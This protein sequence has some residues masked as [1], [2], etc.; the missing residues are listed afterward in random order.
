M[1]QTATEKSVSYTFTLRACALHFL[2]SRNLLAGRRWL[3]LH[4]FGKP[5]GHI[6]FLRANFISRASSGAMHMLRCVTMHVQIIEWFDRAA[7]LPYQLTYPTQGF[8][9]TLNFGDWPIKYKVPCSGILASD[10]DAQLTRKLLT[11]HPCCWTG[12]ALPCWQAWR[13]HVVSRCVCQ[14]LLR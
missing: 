11:S 6:P 10:C 2:S 13:H 4:S 14:C 1:Q 9:P 12:C 5:C 3:L 8:G 7:S